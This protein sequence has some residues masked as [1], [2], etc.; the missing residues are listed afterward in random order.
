MNIGIYF[1]EMKTRIRRRARDDKRKK[2]RLAEM[3]MFSIPSADA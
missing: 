2:A 3:L 1:A